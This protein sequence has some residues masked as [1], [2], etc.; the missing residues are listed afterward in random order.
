MVPLKSAAVICLVYFTIFVNSDRKS[1]CN[2]VLKKLDNMESLCQGTSVRN[3]SSRRMP[4]VLWTFTNC[5]WNILGL[6]YLAVIEF[7]FV[8]YEEFCSSPRVFSTEAEDSEKHFWHFPNCQLETEVFGDYLRN[9]RRVNEPGWFWFNFKNK[10]TNK[11]SFEK[12]HC[13]TTSCRGKWKELTSLRIAFSKRLRQYFP[14]ERN[15]YLLRHETCSV[16]HDI[17]ENF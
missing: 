3:V 4:T 9:Y 14:R 8:G 10:E 1:I 7:A 2:T 6:S 5:S 13:V 12:K 11:E 15:N 16:F 17:L